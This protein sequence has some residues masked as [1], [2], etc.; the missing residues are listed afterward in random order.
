M[1]L[2]AMIVREESVSVQVRHAVPNAEIRNHSSPSLSKQESA[3]A[4]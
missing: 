4:D 2:C 3:E 1:F